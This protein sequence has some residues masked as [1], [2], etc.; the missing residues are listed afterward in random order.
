MTG[1]DSA[2]ATP[3]R[4]RYAFLGPAGTFTE[5]ALRKVADRPR[6]SSCLRAPC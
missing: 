4:L 2:D 5:A 6:P 3:S 1:T